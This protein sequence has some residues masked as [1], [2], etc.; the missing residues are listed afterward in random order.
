MSF[1]LRCLPAVLSNLHC[2]DEY[3]FGLQMMSSTKLNLSTWSSIENCYPTVS[4]WAG[5]L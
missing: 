4:K 2:M 1:I 3:S 5:E